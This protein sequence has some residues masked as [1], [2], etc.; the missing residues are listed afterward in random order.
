VLLA[1]DEFPYHQI[2][3]TF[4]AVA[5]SD[6]QWN[7]GH[8]V[9]LC[10]LEGRVALTSTVR[11]YQNNDVLD[12][13]VCLRHDGRQHNIR[14]SRRLRPDMDH[15]GVGPLSI[16][17]VEPMRQ[18][19]LVLED[20][21]IGIALDVLCR[22]TTLPYMDPVEIT[23]I[24]GRLISERATYELTGRCAGWVSVGGE[25]FE[26]TEDTTSFFRNHSWGYQAG[27]GGPRLW[28]APLGTPR[29]VPGVRQWVLFNM[30]DH[31]GFYFQDPRRR[32]ASGHGMILHADRAVP[33]RTVE[34]DL[35]FYEGGRRLRG[36]SVALL[37]EEGTT[38]TYEVE[39][40]GWVY[41]QG[42]GYFG[43]FADG[44][45]QGVYRGDYHAEGEVWDVS[46][47]T[48]IVDADGKAFEFD[49]DWAESFTR[50][51]C[52]GQVG[53]AHFECVVIQPPAAT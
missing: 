35:R 22:T 34:H 46:H 9:C 40:M 32:A 39:D 26:L 8:Y 27:R 3:D 17:L 33:V 43:G 30:P 7:D 21:D 12:G 37:D 28:G 16:E 2:T 49:H 51:R 29:R 31:G 53:L 15:L 41:C 10:D 25:R 45:G 18:L 44:L 19:R 52:D 50:M 5:G 38:R 48:Q 11:L 1:M 14:L 47:P 6:P 4:A 42:G 20:N 24:D 23:R 13:F 36:G